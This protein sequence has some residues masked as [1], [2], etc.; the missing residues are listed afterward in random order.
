MLSV[1]TCMNHDNFT[2]KLVMIGL[3]MLK[4][5]SI[6]MFKI[7]AAAILEICKLKKCHHLYSM[8]IHAEM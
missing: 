3:Y 2:E 1:Y 7:A 6:F 4:Y 5:A 8:F